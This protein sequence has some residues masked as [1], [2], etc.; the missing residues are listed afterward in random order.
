MR[1][2]SGKTGVDVNKKVQ[3]SSGKRMAI[4]SGGGR[5]DCVP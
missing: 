4:L 1:Q 2:V 3:T 5:S